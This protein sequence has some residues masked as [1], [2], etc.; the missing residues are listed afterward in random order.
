MR[1]YGFR[2]S[3]IQ[4]SIFKLVTAYAGLK[5]RYE[6]LK[7]DDTCSVSDLHLFDITDHIYKANN[8]LFLGTFA[9][10]K[11]IPQMYKG[12][13]IP[14]SLHHNLG[15]MDLI[16]AIETS[17]NPYFSILAGDYLKN[18]DALREA[19]VDF[20]YGEKT[21]ISLPGEIAGNVPNDL[22]TNR[23]GLY[24][25]AIGQHTLI[26]TPLQTAVMLS[27]I[28]NG[29]KIIQPKIV[30]LAA[31]KTMLPLAP[32][33]FQKMPHEHNE[34]VD[35]PVAVKRT[36]FFP[37]PIRSTIL[38]GMKR[39]AQRALDDGAGLSRL[40]ARHPSMH[41][42]FVG[43]RGQFVG[44]TSTAEVIERVGLDVVNPSAMYRHIWFG[45]ISFTKNP[46]KEHSFVFSDA[47]GQPELVVIVYLRFGGYGKEA[48][49]IAAQVVQKW[50][51]IA[52]KHG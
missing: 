45:G 39:S 43:L 24:A 21:G 16:R 38:A 1:P 29:G 49:P 42:D 23:T 10:G 35:V 47:F 8:R 19:A 48:A 14:K 44:K 34:V 33:E 3:T 6:E 18:P 41:K 46:Q 27:A 12:G 51:E 28:A 26:T 40:F 9:D 11:P 7:A 5:Q 36:L 4:G 13:R 37:Q 31:G 17:S 30:R 22:L 50:R 52:Q 20:G 2:Q 32:I 25:T 15:K